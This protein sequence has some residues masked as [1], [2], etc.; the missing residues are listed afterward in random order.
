MLAAFL[1]LSLPLLTIHLAL[2]GYGDI[3]MAL[4]S[5]LGLALLVFGISNSNT[6]ALFI[7]L[8]LLMM[9]TQIKT[10]GWVW[11]GIGCIFLV[12]QWSL[13]LKIVKPILVTVSLLTVLLWS[14][15]ITTLD[16]GPVGL[17]G[18][19]DRDIMAGPLGPIALR[20]YNPITDYIQ[21]LFLSNNFSLL[22]PLVLAGLVSLLLFHRREFLGHG[23]MILL[24]AA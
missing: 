4:Y 1:T 3:W 17:W 24:I 13:Q 12:I 7:A 11:L 8:I 23:T 14:L 9:G 21:A 16:L 20:P 5:G 22:F 6:S 18:L 10:E 19:T 2:A 15:G